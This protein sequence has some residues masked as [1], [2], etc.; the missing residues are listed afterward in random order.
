LLNRPDEVAP[1]DFAPLICLRPVLAHFEIE[2]ERARRNGLK[3]GLL[4]AVNAERRPDQK[5]QDQSEQQGEKADNAADHVARA[6]RGVML[7]KP[8]L[9]KEAD[10]AAGHDERADD[11]RD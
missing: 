6:L 9:Q 8:F 3:S 5:T 11:E 4:G 7:R 10:E 1:Q 2:F